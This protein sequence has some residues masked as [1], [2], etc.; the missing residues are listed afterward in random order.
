MTMICFFTH[1]PEFCAKISYFSKIK[2]YMHI[3]YNI[4]EDYTNC[5]C[6]YH[7]KV[8]PVSGCDRHIYVY[9]LKERLA[10]MV[11]EMSY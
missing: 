3:L 5:T 10:V 1:F 11:F 6:H 7:N 8:I 9:I 2:E 4:N